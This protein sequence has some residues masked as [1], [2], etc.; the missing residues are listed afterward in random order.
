MFTDR[1]STPLDTLKRFIHPHLH[2]FNQIF[3]EDAA[4]SFGHIAVLCI[5]TFT[6]GWDARQIASCLLSISP[7]HGSDFFAVVRRLGQAL[8]RDPAAFW[9]RAQFALRELASGPSGGR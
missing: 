1:F 9:P 4:D 6:R 5:E 3:K 8:R 2:C 7:K